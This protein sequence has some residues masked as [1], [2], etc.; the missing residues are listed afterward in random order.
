MSLRWLKNGVRRIVWTSIKLV[1]DL[2]I[3]INVSTSIAIYKN[4]I[5]QNI[6][7]FIDS[8]QYTWLLDLPAFLCYLAFIIY[9]QLIIFSISLTQL[10]AITFIFY[11]F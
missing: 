2:C 7:Q 1:C 6:N 11:F 9:A 4:L 10:S 3:L 8:F 5:L